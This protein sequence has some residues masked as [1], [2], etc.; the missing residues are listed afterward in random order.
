MQEASKL[1]KWKVYVGPSPRRE[2]GS[3]FLQYERSNGLQAMADLSFANLVIA[4]QCDYFVGDLDS[5]W[6]QI[7][8][9]LR[10]TGGKLLQGY[11]A[12]H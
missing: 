4:S 5:K 1:K 2:P 6:S 10:E 12:I 3:L 7:I 11:F 8:N 9:A